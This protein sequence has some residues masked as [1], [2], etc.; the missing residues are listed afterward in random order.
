MALQMATSSSQLSHLHGAVAHHTRWRLGR[1]AS[2]AMC[3]SMGFARHS[4]P[5]TPPGCWCPAGCTP[6]KPA[7]GAQHSVQAR[8]RCAA[9]RASPSACRT[10]QHS[11]KLGSQCCSV[12][13]HSSNMMEM[14]QLR[15]GIGGRQYEMSCQIRGDVVQ[16]SVHSRQKGH[17][18]M[19]H[20]LQTKGWLGGPTEQRS[21]GGSQQLSPTLAAALLPPQRRSQQRVVAHEER[22]APPAQRVGQHKLVPHSGVDDLRGAAAD[23]TVKC[24]PYKH[25]ASTTSNHTWRARPAG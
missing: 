25:G 5:S 18:M 24:V 16:A 15:N 7:S 20:Q 19:P 21:A 13:S 22:L 12:F 3:H 17:D 6:C 8:Q 9:L 23:E 14:N 4:Y 2:T 1:A 10:H 11:L